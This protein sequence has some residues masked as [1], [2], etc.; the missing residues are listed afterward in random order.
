MSKNWIVAKTQTK[1]KTTTN[2]KHNLPAAPN[3]VNQNFDVDR[4]NILRVGDITYVPQTRWVYFAQVMV[5]Y[6]R[7]A[8]SWGVDKRMKKDLVMKAMKRALMN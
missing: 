7:G 3:L 4:P 5:V 6:N 1:F 2:S 8:I